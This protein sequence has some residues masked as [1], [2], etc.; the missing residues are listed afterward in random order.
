MTMTEPGGAVSTKCSFS[1]GAEVSDAKTILTVYAGPQIRMDGWPVGGAGDIM[2]MS[3]RCP[4]SGMPNLTRASEISQVEKLENIQSDNHMQFI[5]RLTKTV[6]Q[7]QRARCVFLA[8]SNTCAHGTGGIVSPKAQLPVLTSRVG[9]YNS[10]PLPQPGPSFTRLHMSA[11]ELFCHP[12]LSFQ[13][14]RSGWPSY[15]GSH[16]SW[17]QHTKRVARLGIFSHS[18]CPR[19]SLRHVRSRFLL[20][21]RCS[22]NSFLHFTI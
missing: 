8:D 1:L 15:E 18:T 9:L 21:C 7:S 17:R 4:P 20:F 5:S 19:P 10:S 2:R 13:I 6:T 16:P 12:Y 11:T 14:Q 3:G 22:P